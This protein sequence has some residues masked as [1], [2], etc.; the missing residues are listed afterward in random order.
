MPS[1]AG[2]RACPTSPATARMV[3]RYGVIARNCDGI[4]DPIIP[5]WTLSA[6][7]KPKSSAAASAPLGLHRPR[8][9]AASAIYPLPD[10]I[11][12]PNASPDATV[13]KAP[14]SP[15]IAPPSMVLR[16]RVRLT[17]MPT[18][19]AALGCSPTDRTRKPQR[20]LNSMIW[21][22]ITTAYIR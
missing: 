17:L 9:I 1:A 11:S 5:N 12:L 7:A 15:A 16:I 20:D 4:S 19:S 14:P 13:K 8:I 6:S 2:G 10:V 3:A 22:T 21:N 18:V